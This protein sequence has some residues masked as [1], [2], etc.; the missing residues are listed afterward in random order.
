MG[1]LGVNICICCCCFYDGLIIC[2]VVYLF[3]DLSMQFV[4]LFD[5]GD[6]VL[7]C[8]FSGLL[9]KKWVQPSNISRKSDQACRLKKKEGL[10]AF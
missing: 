9:R 1:G 4:C 7:C 8:L 6:N 10:Y 2:L 3:S 5:V